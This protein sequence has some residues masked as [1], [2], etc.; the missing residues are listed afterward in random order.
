VGAGLGE[1]GMGLR[2]KFW[3]EKDGDLVFS[4]GRRDLLRRIREL[5]SLHRAAKS[6]SMSYRAAWGKIR[7][8]EQR[9][10]WKLVETRGPRKH[11]VLTRRGEEFLDRYTAFEEEAT[12]L[13]EELYRK[14]FPSE[15]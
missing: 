8:T 9:L 13:V 14:R 5:G 15:F 12:R 10:G 6:L 11:L 4:S 7:N 3:L 2:V 1:K